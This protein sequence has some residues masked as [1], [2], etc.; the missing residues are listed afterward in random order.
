MGG[1]M[2]PMGGMMNWS[3]PW[4]GWLMMLIFWG[5]LLAGL[6]GLV[7]LLWPPSR[8]GGAGAEPHRDEAIEALRQRYAR[9]EISRE[10]FIRMEEDLRRSRE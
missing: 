3:G 10:E 7:R 1:M 2:G 4:W 5:L 9:G 6:V 8:A